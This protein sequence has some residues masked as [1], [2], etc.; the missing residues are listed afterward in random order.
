[1]SVILI[2]H[3]SDLNENTVFPR[4]FIYHLYIFVSRTTSLGLNIFFDKYISK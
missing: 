2:R 4:P 3:L 1:M